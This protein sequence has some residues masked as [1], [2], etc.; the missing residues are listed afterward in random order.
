[1]IEKPQRLY[2]P[3]Y[4]NNNFC[5]AN[6]EGVTLSLLFDITDKQKALCYLSQYLKKQKQ[7]FFFSAGWTLWMLWDDLGGA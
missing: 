7:L 4:A 6:I 2:Q 3:L 1:M 5:S